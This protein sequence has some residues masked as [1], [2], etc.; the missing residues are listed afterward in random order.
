MVNAMVTPKKEYT[1]HC[2]Q[3][4]QYP[5]HFISFPLDLDHFFLFLRYFSFF[6]SWPV[7]CTT[8]SFQPKRTQVVFIEL[9]EMPSNRSSGLDFSDGRPPNRTLDQH[10]DLKLNEGSTHLQRNKTERRRLQGLQ[11]S[12]TVTSMTGS[13]DSKNHSWMERFN[14]W[15]INEGGRQLFFGV[16]IFLHLL[17]AVFGFIHYQVKDNLNNARA[18]FGI[19]FGALPVHSPPFTC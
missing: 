3:R 6:T 9:E 5:L 15:M 1:S 2:P 7:V 17:V 8:H 12:L 16:W 10:P 18:T 4:N 13:G 19:T 11:R 14:L